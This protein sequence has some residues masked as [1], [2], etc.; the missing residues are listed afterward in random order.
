MS[1]ASPPAITY[2]EVDLDAIAHN[3]RAL[4]AFIGPAVELFAV[5]KANAY[6]HGLVPV[7][8]T[9]LR[10][11]VSRLA[12]GRLSEGLQLRQAGIAAPVLA[13]CYLMP[14]ELR[15]AVEHDLVPTVGEME[16]ALVVSALGVARQKPV[17]VH[18][19]ID[20]GMGRYGV[21]PDQAVSFFNQIATLPGLAVEGVFTHF[22]TADERDKTFAREQFQ[23]FQ[24]V[25]AELSVAGHSIPLLHAANSAAALDLPETHLGAVRSGLALYGLYPSESVSHALPLKPALTLKS[26]VASV[27]QL[28]AGAGISYGRSYITPRPMTVALVPIGYGDGYHRLLSNRGAVLVNGQ[29]APIVGRVCMD[30]VV[31]DV[32]GCGPVALN[33]EVVLIGQQGDARI[34]VE[35]I[36]GW[37]ETISYEITSALLA[38]LPRFFRGG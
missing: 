14:D 1:D 17:P 35:E 36:A 30:Q 18:V 34:T 8:Q 21:M 4:K 5:V 31:V 28:P 20:T 37:A 26:H 13:L 16:S 2:I 29:R 10:H 24:D 11:G 22:A 3:V 19:K 27:R 32:S 12:I 23:I 9:V 38:R 33:D 25:L 7:A 6:G 15:I